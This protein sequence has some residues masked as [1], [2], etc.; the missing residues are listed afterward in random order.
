MI[1]EFCEQQVPPGKK[2]GVECS[3][4]RVICKACIHDAHLAINDKKTNHIKVISLA[5]YK[6]YKLWEK[7]AGVDKDGN[8]I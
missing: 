5:N 2:G 8:I 4:G 3:N 7:G 1:C 6:S